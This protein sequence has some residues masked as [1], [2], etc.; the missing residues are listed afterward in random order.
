MA[1]NR[2]CMCGCRNAGLLWLRA[3][4]Q[5]EDRTEGCDRVFP[6][7]GAH[8]WHCWPWVGSGYAAAAQNTLDGQ[9]SGSLKCTLVCFYSRFEKKKKVSSP[10]TISP[11]CPDFRRA[12][13]VAWLWAESTQAWTHCWSTDEARPGPKW[14][15]SCWIR[16]RSKW[17]PTFPYLFK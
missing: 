11:P 13:T 1:T 12:K 9:K 17:G 15:G 14:S 5:T 10:E 8:R 4:C 7:T 6:G 16:C 3:G 2:L